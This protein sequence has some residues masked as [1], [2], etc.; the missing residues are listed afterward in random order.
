M[1]PAQSANILLVARRDPQ[2]PVR[3]ILKGA[4][5]AVVIADSPSSVVRTAERSGPALIV[6]EPGA[7]AA[8][9][10]ESLVTFA[11]AHQIQVIRDWSGSESLLAQ[12]E[13]AL[14][15]PQSEARETPCITV[16]LLTVDLA[17][18][19]AT[20]GGLP[21]D[22]TAREFELLCHLARHPGWVY[23][24]QEL[25]EQVWGYEFGDPR[26]VTVHMANL[27]K[28]LDSALPG[29]E[30]IETVRNVGYKLVAPVTDHPAGVDQHTP[31]PASVPDRQVPQIAEPS[32]S[33]PRADERRQ[34][35]VLVAHVSGL[36]A[37]ADALEFR[38]LREIADNVFERLAPCV[39]RY[40]GQVERRSPDS[41][42][43][44]FGAPVAHDD[45]A[46]R[47]LRAAADLRDEAAQ[48]KAEKG[49]QSLSIH[50]GVSTGTVIAGSTGDELRDY[51]AVGEPLDA[52]SALAGMAGADEV[53]ADSETV[54]LAGGVAA[55]EG[56]G[57]IAVRGR[58]EGLSF[59]RVT[60]VIPGRQPERSLGI[61]SEL[62]G[63]DEHMALFRAA[64]SRLEDGAGSIVF[65]LG[66]AGV[67]KSRLTSE[68]RHEAI[69]RGLKWLEARTLSYGQNIS[70]LPFREVI[71][72]D[73]GI[74]PGDPVEERARKLRERFSRL[75][76]DKAADF[77]P[78]L[79]GLLGIGDEESGH[80][81]PLPPEEEGVRRSLVDTFGR[82]IRRLS[83]ERP[84]IVA[85]EDVHWLDRSSTVLIEK[86]LPVVSETPVILCL[87]GRPAAGSPTL[88]LLDTARRDQA[89]HSVEIALKRLTRRQTQQLV[90]NLLSGT[91]VEP[92]V[93]RLV[94][95]RSEG[96]PF[97]VEE[98]IRHLADAG[99]LV[100][101][102]RDNW[103]ISGTPG[104]LEVPAT[105][106][107]VISARVDR[108]PESAR[109][110]LLQAS[111]IG[112]SFY[113]RLLRALSNADD[114]G[115]ES[116]LRSLQDHQLIFLKR[117]EPEPEYTFIHALVQ[118]AAY[119]TLLLK[120]R[121]QLHRSVAKAIEELYSEQARDLYGILA[122][123]YTK[124]EDWRNA[125]EYL[126]KGGNQSVS[127][128]ADAESVAQ[129]QEAMAALL[130]AFDETWDQAGT[131]DQVAWFVS[132]TEPFWLARC[133][134]DL[135]DSADIFYKKILA[136]CGPEDPRTM[137]ATTVLA[138]CY[139]QRGMYGEAIRLVEEALKALERSRR[140][141]DSSTTRLLLLLGICRINIAQFAEAVALLEHAFALESGKSEPDEGL[142][143]ELYLILSSAYHFNGRADD[144]RKLLAEAMERFDFRGTQRYWMMLLNLSDV[145]RI[146]GRWEEAKEQNQQILDGASSPFIRA[147]AAVNLAEVRLAEG[148][149]LDAEEQLKYAAA[150]FEELG[151]VSR[152]VEALADLA[153]TQLR[154]GKTDKA[155]QTARDV[156]ALVKAASLNFSEAE[157]LWTLAGVALAK[158][159]Y[160]E[161]DSLL[162]A[163]TSVARAKY[164][165]RHP[166]H[167]ELFFRLAELKAKQGLLE[168][169]QAEFERAVSFLANATSAAHPLIKQMEGRWSEI[170]SRITPVS[171]QQD[172]L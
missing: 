65:V 81:E 32:P 47:G 154:A 100:R 60:G 31:E 61:R 14:G 54:A 107:G 49:A 123:H 82:Y 12:I 66:E 153:E 46:E 72:V 119:N 98:L 95:S 97:F 162:A 163:S 1:A 77:V 138:G 44:L 13:R 127:L 144:M 170:T 53:L 91:A 24:R 23:S 5:Y 90:R 43:A 8:T 94:E 62:V 22:L 34:A 131:G 104:E 87:V 111:V 58:A 84:L 36:A 68:I 85:I 148:A 121:K 164:S 51:S 165:V 6:V 161:A 69:E 102:E 126:L 150:V 157:G 73:C 96:N 168:E 71:Q 18:H 27:R 63:R 141:D 38:S 133:L 143:Q 10:T 59:H 103:T 152:R 78:L 79:G 101:D 20:V 169:G 75:F 155:E 11:A 159:D 129:Y 108:L 146:D 39:A 109:Q 166:L 41:F 172:G 105:I 137:A 74:E 2:D 116:D 35:T 64:I 171:A 130:R 110:H 17:G 45:D 48:F 30:L 158:G 114:Q 135:L 37:L 4:G 156:L 25:L 50:V 145:N 29:S 16:G 3:R 40:D 132:A 89:G 134:G 128:A 56:G 125:Q 9:I 106:H 33:R 160:S 19:S 52:A 55:C 57:S 26:V 99:L 92:R 86:L 142:L 28:K 15:G 136:A 113:R 83:T 93:V 151:E 67:G 88:E 147:F 112:R 80:G 42:V 117:Q 118:E 70:Y 120:Q 122:Y 115:F 167:G 124:A 7:L 149:Y 139:Y 140:A 21:L 76:A